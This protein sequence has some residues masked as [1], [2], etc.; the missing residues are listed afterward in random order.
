VLVKENDDKCLLPRSEDEMSDIKNKDPMIIYE[1]MKELMNELLF[2]T[3]AVEDD[4]FE[5]N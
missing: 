2:L 3:D 5:A 4:Q 1:R